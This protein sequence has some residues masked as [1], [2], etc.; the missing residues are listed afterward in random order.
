M[1]TKPEY[2]K[3]ALL[4]ARRN[5]FDTVHFCGMLDGKEVYT[6]D[7]NEYRVVGLPQLI[8]TDGK[9]SSLYNGAE[10]FKIIDAC[11]KLP[12]VVFEYDRMC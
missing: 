12:W 2:R 11:Q 10:P 1:K 8:I 3:E 7:Y 5:D 9:K 6:G 4:F